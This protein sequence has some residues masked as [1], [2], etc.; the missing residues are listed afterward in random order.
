MLK[1]NLTNATLLLITIL[2]L[3]LTVSGQSS[4][5]KPLP[6]PKPRVAACGLTIEESPTLRGFR[7]RQTLAELSAKFP[8]LQV[9]YKEAQFKDA[10]AASLGKVVVNSQ[11]ILTIAGDATPE[12]DDVVFHLLFLDEIL[13][14]IWIEYAQYEPDHIHEFITHVSQTTAL[15][16]GYWTKL[17]AH[18]A[19][20]ECKGFEARLSAVQ[21]FDDVKI[22]LF[23]SFG[24]YD[25]SAIAEQNRRDQA[26]AT[27]KVQAE[28]E[29][30]RVEMERKKRF[31]P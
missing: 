30:S 29:K 12:F 9:A 24:I 27:K 7:L 2:I 17:D 21:K 11:N 6:T 25:L 4:M 13:F 10:Y 1:T 31:K 20:A 15:K 18:S 16:Y 19:R 8:R 3:G 5:P 23:P 22:E 26:L 14:G 28:Q